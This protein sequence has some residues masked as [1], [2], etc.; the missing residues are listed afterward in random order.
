MTLVWV[1]EDTVV[2]IWRRAIVA[3]KTLPAV[4]VAPK[5]TL[6]DDADIAVPRA[7][8][9]TRVIVILGHH[10]IFVLELAIRVR[11]ANL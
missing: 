6:I 3:I 9:P 5:V 1:I 4:G 8:V 10:T 11:V 2:L 7:K